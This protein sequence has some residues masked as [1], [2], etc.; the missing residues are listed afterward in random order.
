ME[1]NIKILIISRFLSHHKGYAQCKLLNRKILL[2]LH[3]IENCLEGKLAQCNPL[4]HSASQ[5]QTFQCL[6]KNI[7]FKFL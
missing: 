2:R 5:T 4:G 7:I 1:E 3:M 6:K